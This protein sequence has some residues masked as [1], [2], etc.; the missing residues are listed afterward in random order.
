MPVAIHTLIWLFP[1]A[2]MCH[3]F[4]E[5][6][7]GEPWLRK[8]A[9]ALQERIR[10]SVPAWAAKQI[11]A[12][13]AKSAAELALPISLIFGLTCLAAG[14]ALAVQAYGF[15]LLASSA[16]SLH[17]FMHLG[18]AILLRR[19]VPAVLTSGLIVIPYGLVLDWSLLRAGLVDLPGLLIYA[20]L[21]VVLTIPF[22]LVMHKVGDTLYRV[23]VRLLIN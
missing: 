5:L 11:G 20:L 4:E 3:D 19:Y 9:A 6:I 1:L 14:L 13:L 12:V 2:F 15:F 18:Q 7:L 10:T 21:A 22:I 16:F 8:N 17:G 23:A